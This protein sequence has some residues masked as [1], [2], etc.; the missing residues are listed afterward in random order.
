M[1]P[2]CTADWSLFVRDVLPVAFVNGTWRKHRA[3]LLLDREKALLP[4]T[5]EAASSNQHLKA[6]KAHATTLK[7]ELKEH[8]RISALIKERMR[9]FR[10]MRAAAAVTQHD[11]DV[12]RRPLGTSEDGIV[13]AAGAAAGGAVAAAT[14]GP[15][16]QENCRGFLS[17]DWTCGQCQC[18]VCRDCREVLHQGNQ[19][20]AAAA[21]SSSSSAAA[22]AAPHVCK[23]DTLASVK[24]AQENTKPCP[25]CRVPI[26]RSYGCDHMFC[27]QCKASWNWK[28]EKLIDVS[29]NSNPHLHEF[30]ARQRA[31]AAAAGGGGGGGAAAAAAN[32]NNNNNNECG[33]GEVRAFDAHLPSEVDR[34]LN[35]GLKL[36]GHS[37]PST[38]RESL[39]HMLDS[40]AHMIR[41]VWPRYRDAAGL[42]TADDSAFRQ[43]RVAYLDNK[44]T[45]AQW[46][47]RILFRD[48]KIARRTEIRHVLELWLQTGSDVCARVHTSIRQN[49]DARGMELLHV[50]YMIQSTT[51]SSAPKFGDTLKS[52]QEFATELTELF[53]YCNR[54]MAIVSTKFACKV[55]HT[56]DKTHL[57]SDRRMASTFVP[58]KAIKTTKGTKAKSTTKTTK[59]KANAKKTTVSSSS[60]SS[61]ASE[62]SSDDDD[63][64]NM[65]SESDAEEEE[66]DSEEE[67]E[68][69]SPRRKQ[70]KNN[71]RK[72]HSKNFTSDD[73]EETDGDDD[74]D[75]NKRVSNAPASSSATAAA[76]SK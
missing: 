45:E 4:H 37:I 10:N 29:R 19:V 21:S 68:K 67:E 54:Q 20:A 66:E 11:A 28:T 36:P 74:N 18:R 26:Q 53:A 43:L 23:A 47:K 32:N 44:I 46:K 7:V 15:C 24:L 49:V 62:S 57:Y 55:P 30:R 14:V 12:F 27:V 58:R 51:L 72:R 3:N 56:D 34:I 40:I 64:D 70:T 8:K 75:N 65:S 39:R 63:D 5:N 61:S 48:S 1:K 17:A 71:K 31:A 9:F 73:D 60:S 2:G 22:A 25:S 52:V 13:V 35:A 6:I 59:G 16:P 50:R 42:A 38:L 41:V 76:A 33:G 69:S